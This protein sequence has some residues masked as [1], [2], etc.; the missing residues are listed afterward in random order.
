MAEAALKGCADE[1]RGA[2]K[3]LKLARAK[4]QTLVGELDETKQKVYGDS[5]MAG[6]TVRNRELKLKFLK[7]L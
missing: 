3:E 7:K 2:Q 6:G 5:G 1:N 4:I